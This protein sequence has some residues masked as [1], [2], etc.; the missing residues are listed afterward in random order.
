MSDDKIK[1]LN[2]TSLACGVAITMRHS[3]G[4]WRRTTPIQVRWDLTRS[5][6]KRQ[7]L[8]MQR[9]SKKDGGSFHQALY[10]GRRNRRRGLRHSMA[11][12]ANAMTDNLPDG[13]P[14]E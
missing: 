13:A 8:L 4:S 5:W 1:Q 14:D 11:S 2:S 10:G 12:Y 6:S 3:P 7:G 9:W